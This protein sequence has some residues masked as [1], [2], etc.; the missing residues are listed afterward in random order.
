MLNS[1]NIYAFGLLFLRFFDYEFPNIGFK[2]KGQVALDYLLGNQILKKVFIVFSEHIMK[3]MHESLVLSII[4]KCVE[5]I[6]KDRWNFIQI[7]YHIQQCLPKKEEKEENKENKE[8]ENK[9]KEEKKGNKRKEEEE[10][11]K[12]DEEKKEKEE[13]KVNLS[14]LTISDTKELQKKAIIAIFNMLYSCHL[15]VLS[16]K[17]KDE[18]IRKFI[19]LIKNDQNLL[20][21]LQNGELMYFSTSC[22]AESILAKG[23][24]KAESKPKFFS[25]S[26]TIF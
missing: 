1:S 21:R 26:Q 16:G 2:C 23:M 6:L 5:P 22:I 11:K 4:N 24:S 13:N 10:E 14:I 20:E 7:I 8:K 15:A 12:E 19:L 17:N 3:L 9:E 18:A 25:G